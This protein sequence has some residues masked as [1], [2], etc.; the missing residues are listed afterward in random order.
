M[1]ARYAA[2]VGVSA[3]TA[4]SAPAAARL[5]GPL[6]LLPGAAGDHFPNWGLNT[7][8]GGDDPSVTIPAVPEPATGAVALLVTALL[9]LG[10][11]PRGTRGR[12]R[13]PCS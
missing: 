6:A 9:A 11:R 5:A 3:A 7:P 8:A 2:P 4:G 10:R 12:V 1:S 13:R